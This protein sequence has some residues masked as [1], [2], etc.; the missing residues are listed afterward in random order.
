MGTGPA[1]VYY[2]DDVSGILD[3][4]TIANIV[5]G[6]GLTAVLDPATGRLIITGQVQPGQTITVTYMATVNP[7]GQR[8]DNVLF[9]AVYP[10]GTPISD[11]PTQGV[12]VAQ[13]PACSTLLVASSDVVIQPEPVEG[14][15]V[16]GSQSVPVSSATA[17]VTRASTGGQVVSGGL[18]WPSLVFVALGAVGFGGGLIGK[19]VMSKR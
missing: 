5:A 4:A 9:E 8:G 16:S 14:P 11:Q 18:W 3:D 2:I 1:E 6:T 13:C 17:V 7:D 12:S 10:G 15:S 19:K